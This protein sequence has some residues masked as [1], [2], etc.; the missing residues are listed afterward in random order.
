MAKHLRS[1]PLARVYVYGNSPSIY[2]VYSYFLFLLQGIPFL[3][4]T[5]IISYSIV[6]EPADRNSSAVTSCYSTFG[7][8]IRNILLLLFYINFLSLDLFFPAFGFHVFGCPFTVFL[9]LFFI[10][11]KCQPVSL[12]DFEQKWIVLI[13]MSPSL[14]PLVEREHVGW[15]VALCKIIVA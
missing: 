11:P 4:A 13:I 7:D 5:Y 8:Y 1:G 6:S 12:P 9:L 10:S 2:H 14:S 15:W 3:P